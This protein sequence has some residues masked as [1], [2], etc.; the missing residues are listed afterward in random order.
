MVPAGP[1]GP[2]GPAGPEGPQGKA[3]QEETYTG[4]VVIEAKLTEEYWQ[5]P[6]HRNEYP[7]LSYGTW[8]IEDERIKPH[9]ILQILLTD[10]WI[11]D[12]GTPGQ[13]ILDYRYESNVS[14]GVVSIV[15]LEWVVTK[16]DGSK[17]FGGYEYGDML[18]IF[19]AVLE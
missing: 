15:S 3:A 9:A 18:R 2:P 8:V 17:V 14:D 16:E 6:A 11:E 19:V 12:D 4:L 13:E 5:P 7:A 10:T 1:M